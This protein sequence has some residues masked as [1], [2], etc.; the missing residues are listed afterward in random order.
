M[1]ELVTSLAEEEQRIID[2]WKDKNLIIMESID[3]VCYV[4]SGK[5]EMEYESCFG[6][7][8]KAFEKKQRYKL[9]IPQ[10]VIKYYQYYLL[11]TQDE[12]GQWYVGGM[13][14]NGNV[15]F[16]K[17]CENLEYAFESL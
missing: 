14:K 9:A 4:L 1:V 16:Y 3:F 11:E 7:T 5:G 8:T 17:C 13:Q 2:Q 12:I 10:K 6:E 15:E